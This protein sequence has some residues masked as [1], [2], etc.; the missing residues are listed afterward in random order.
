MATTQKSEQEPSSSSCQGDLRATD[1]SLVAG[2]V[3]ESPL[4]CLSVDSL[5]LLRARSIT[6]DI[7]VEHS[8]EGVSYR[9]EL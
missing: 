3:E 8:L 6:Y 5:A 1:P 9:R 2:L 7:R 4:G